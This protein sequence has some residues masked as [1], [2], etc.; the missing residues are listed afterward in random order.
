MSGRRRVRARGH[1]DAP[2]HVD[3]GANGR[4]LCQS[5]A[6]RRSDASGAARVQCFKSRHDAHSGVGSGLFQSNPVRSSGLGTNVTSLKQISNSTRRG[7]NCFH[8][9]G[10]HGR[11]RDSTQAKSRRRL[12]LGIPADD[13]RGPGLPHKMRGKGSSTQG[14][15]AS[16]PKW[17]LNLGALCN[18]RMVPSVRGTRVM[19]NLTACTVTYYRLGNN[20]RFIFQ[21]GFEAILGTR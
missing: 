6:R 9:G 14:C 2:S 8:P 12:A 19:R 20:D 10:R 21:Q 5:S 4:G 1:H 7:G 18:E 15:G 3:R 17:S 11:T 16:Q 13:E